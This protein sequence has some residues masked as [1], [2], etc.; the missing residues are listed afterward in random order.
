M[1]ILIDGYNLLHA[2]GIFAAP[3]A[4]PSFRRN[5]EALVRFL[6]ERLADQTAS[7]QIV[8]DAS[9]P[10]PGLPRQTTLFGITIFFASDHDSADQLLEELIQSNHAPRRLTVVSSDHRVQR[11]ARRRRATVVDSDVWFAQLQ[12]QPRNSGDDAIRS[13]TKPEAELEPGAVAYW[14]R[15][16]NLPSPGE[17]VPEPWCPWSNPLP[18]KD[19]LEEDDSFADELPGSPP[20][21]TRRIRGR[22]P[23]TK[24]G[25]RN[26]ERHRG[27][28]DSD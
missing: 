24:R 27:N 10:P 6:A 25:R 5:R 23:A 2:S 26:S 20:H 1:A 21:S 16:F 15:E 13:E 7:T 28:P 4:R 18:V 8:F 9:E 19:A 17:T 3:A 22:P 11:A 14:L 12:A